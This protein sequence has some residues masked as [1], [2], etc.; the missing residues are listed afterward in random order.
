MKHEQPAAAAAAH[1]GPE[2]DRHQH[3]RILGDDARPCR[4]CD[5]VTGTVPGHPEPERIRHRHRRHRQPG[6]RLLRGRRRPRSGVMFI[7]A[8]VVLLAGALDG[9]YG[10]FVFNANGDVVDAFFAEAPMNGSTALLPVAA[11]SLG[12]DEIEHNKFRYDTT[13]SSVLGPEFDVVPGNPR[14]RPASRAQRHAPRFSSVGDQGPNW[15]SGPRLRYADQ[16][17]SRRASRATPM[18]ARKCP[19]RL[20]RDTCQVPN[21]RHGQDC[22]AFGL[23]P[24]ERRIGR[25]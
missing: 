13:G 15:A 14:F 4:G 19:R 21:S 3:D 17:V 20:T 6:A 22:V 25:V 8:V 12:L 5:S 2:T 11:S 24:E 16:C 10:S 1:V 18:S 7:I 9:R 23:D